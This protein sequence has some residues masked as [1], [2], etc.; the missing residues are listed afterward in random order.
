MQRL[1]IDRRRQ[2]EHAAAMVTDL[3]I[4]VDLV[5]DQAMVIERIKI[6]H[7]RL[8]AFGLRILSGGGLRR[9]SFSLATLRFRLRSCL[10]SRRLRT[11]VSAA[12]YRRCQFPLRRRP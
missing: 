9:S 1:A 7:Q 11:M 8:G 5:G 6:A 4:N 10:A 3:A 12:Y 2:P